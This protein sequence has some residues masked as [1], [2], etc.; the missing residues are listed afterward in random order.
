MMETSLRTLLRLLFPRLPLIVKTALLNALSLSKNSSKQGLKT[1]VAVVLLRDITSARR[2]I[3]FMQSYSSKGPPIKGPTVVA[4]VTVP[5]SQ[6]GDG[7]RDVLCSAIKELGYGNEE[8]ALP[9]IA[10]VEA[11]WTGYRNGV[12][13]NAPRPDLPEPEQYKLL[14]K[15]VSSPVTILYFHGGA[16]Y[17]MD[18]ASVRVTTTR[19]AKLTG[20][21]CYS[22]RYRLAPQHPFPAQLLDALVAY[23]YLLH[24]PSGSLHEP[25]PANNIVFSGESAGGNLAI[26]LMQL[27]LTLQRMGISTIRF[28]GADVPV[29]LPA[30]IAVNS[31]WVDITRSL[32]SN[33]INAHYDY[34]EPLGH[35]GLSN[36]EPLPDEFWPTSP[37][38]ADIFCNASSMLH[39]LVSPVQAHP[40]SWKGMPPI[41]MCV[42]NETLEDEVEVLARRMAQGGGKVNFVGYEGMPHCFAMIFPT[43]PTGKDC[44]ERWA[45]F[46]LE[47]VSGSSPSSGSTALWAKA[48]TNPIHF[49]EIDIQRLNNLTDQEVEKITSN[50]QKHFLQR[51]NELVKKWTGQQ[52]TAKI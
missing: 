42:G 10:A 27:L 15:H 46:C 49:E 11:E 7:V 3:G 47:V 45:Q 12:P 48:K 28:H 25:V 2:T 16:Y 52:A 19:L 50:M 13:P 5:P 17:L 4:K 36:T 22:V 37:P 8:Y 39:P 21:R 29:Q 43:S 32:P 40:G 6:D 41:W 14:M 23:L 31:P 1:E 44:F 34:L 20:G 38:R 51:E 9:D 26:A 24:P 33:I 18:P 30:G 35:T